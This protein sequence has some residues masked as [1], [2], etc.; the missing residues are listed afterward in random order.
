MRPIYLQTRH[1]TL[2][3]AF[4]ANKA[5][6]KVLDL[7]SMVEAAEREAMLQAFIFQMARL[8]EAAK[9]TQRR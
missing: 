6:E 2:G 1:K 8:S 9:D 4:A 5:E 3:I 7:G